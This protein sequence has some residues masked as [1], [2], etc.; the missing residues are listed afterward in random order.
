MKRLALLGL[1]LLVSG[2]TDPD[3]ARNVLE[4]AGY[5]A[6]EITPNPRTFS[7]GCGD[8]DTYATHFRANGPTGIPIEGVVCSQGANG[9]G[10]TIRIMNVLRRD[11]GPIAPQSGVR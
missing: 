1:V 11:H 5:G 10:A 9:K 3:G 7:T 8:S 2:C 6:V 4:A